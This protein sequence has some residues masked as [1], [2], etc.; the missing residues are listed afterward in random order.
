MEDK[1]Y[2]VSHREKEEAMHTAKRQA[3]PEI[4]ICMILFAINKYKKDNV[5]LLI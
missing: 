5:K 3:L 2:N 4:A 1:S